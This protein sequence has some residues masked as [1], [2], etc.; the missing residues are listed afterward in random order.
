[1]KNREK[2]FRA[3]KP[4]TVCTVLILVFLLSLSACSP[5]NKLPQSAGSFS[6]A[7]ISY[8]RLS[9]YVLDGKNSNLYYIPLS[10]DEVE[11]CRSVFTDPK[12]EKI[13]PEDYVGLFLVE[14]NTEQKFTVYESLSGGYCFSYADSLGIRANE[15]A[16]MLLDKIEKSSGQ[17]AHITLLDF[18]SASRVELIKDGEVLWST[19][20]EAVITEIDSLLDAYIGSGPSNFDN[21]DYELKCTFADGSEHTLLLSSDDGF[22]FVPPLRYYKLPKLSPLRQDG[23]TD[24]FGTD[25]WP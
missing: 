24:I 13:E 25:N 5:A 9:Y 18:K 12:T 17:D 19:E 8:P 3:N 10:E 22:I 15:T 20:N 2:N 21:Y 6:E 1:M 4:R 11:S 7:D 14:F 16:K 23:W